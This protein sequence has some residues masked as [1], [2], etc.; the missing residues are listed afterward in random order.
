M[1]DLRRTT[2]HPVG[3]GRSVDVL[4]ARMRE[5]QRVLRASIHDGVY[6]LTPVVDVRPGHVVMHLTDTGA[7]TFL[8]GHVA[9]EVDVARGV[10][11]WGGARAVGAWSRLY[12]THGEKRLTLY[13]AEDD[14][15]LRV[16]VRW[17]ADT[18]EVPW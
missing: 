3:S 9:V 17:L 2:I 1:S 5:L 11:S 13:E 14:P 10:D 16:W 8:L 15:P 6:T 12:D 4:D 18:E 7:R